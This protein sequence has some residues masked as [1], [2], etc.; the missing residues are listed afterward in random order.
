MYRRITFLCFTILWSLAGHA[1]KPWAVGSFPDEGGF[2]QRMA[3]MLERLASR[4]FLQRGMAPS[5]CPDTGLPVN[6]WAL[7]GELIRSPYTGRTY[8]QG[9]T[10]YFG[11]KAR[12]DQ[13]EITAF[14]GDPLKY[15]LPPATATLLLNPEE[16]K[17]RAYLSIPGHLNQQYH[18]ACKNWARFYPLLAKPMGV[19]WQR[20][21][22]EAV[23]GYAESRRPS[24]GAREWAP[25]SRPHTLVGE[26]GELLGGNTVDGGTENH[27][28][29][30]RT[31]AL[32]YAQ[33]FPDSARI[34]GY[35]IADTRRLVS[36]MVYDYGRRLLRTGNGEYDSQVYYPHSIEAFL[37]LYDFSTDPALKH[38]AKYMLDYYFLTYGLKVVDGAIAG[39]QKRG[40]LP[41]GEPGEMETMLWA[42]GAP[43]SRKMREAE[44][45]L[46]QATTSYRPNAVI[47][48]L[49]RQEVPLPYSARMARPFYHMDRYNA[50]QESF[51]RSQSFGLGNVYMPIVDNPNQQMVWS[52]IVEGRAGPLGFT[53]G[54]PWALTTSGHSPYT[55]TA[56]HR[57]AVIV[58]S[59][60][61]PDYT[62]GQAFSVNPQR[63]NPWHLPDSAQVSDF[64]RAN[65]QQ[66]AAE[67]L[68]EVERPQED[69]PNSLQAFWDDKK[70][71]AASWLL[72]PKAVDSLYRAGEF[73]ILEAPQTWVVVRPLA[74][75]AYLLSAAPEV[76]EQVPNRTWR[77]ILSHYDL[78]VVPGMISGYTLEAVEKLEVPDLDGLK[79]YLGAK[80]PFD[81]QALADELR[82]TYRTYSGDR[83]ELRYLPYGLKG[84][85]KVNGQALDWNSWA[86]GG[87]YQSDLLSIKE[88]RL[89]VD[90]EGEGYRVD[91]TGPSP[92]YRQLT[93][94]R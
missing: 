33:H 67:R 52:L 94:D 87:V 42:F 1:Q 43:T 18:F 38:L 40:Y 11:P 49:L 62:G 77:R 58:L 50:F 73:F 22:Q 93:D 31:S 6:N 21:F 78:L 74:S 5:I 68:R 29:M 71:S 63:L 80:E 83:L 75:D 30:W 20:R 36:D 60:P 57:G 4:P 28:T 66:Y 48:R 13:G 35:S 85:V 7:E 46:H 27:K 86:D 79:A 59:A 51:Y 65:R 72:I 69:D 12:N 70:W 39:G 16:A 37:N 91:F 82:V 8:V 24:D 44:A 53:G 14:G 89:R 76:A 23:A 45:S 15:A 32:V 88:G 26:P 81:P 56:H 90:L 54:Q 10:G 34:S 55:Q 17:T 64:E 2:Q 19:D 84:E 25:L 61:S 9:P 47:S 41:W 92:L 3:P